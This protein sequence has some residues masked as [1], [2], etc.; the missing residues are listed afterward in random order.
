M[1]KC[2]IL[3]INIRIADAE[4]PAGDLIQQLEP[5]QIDFAEIEKV[6]AAVKA[7]GAER[8]P[9]KQ[10]SSCWEGRKT[11]LLFQMK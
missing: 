6:L 8:Q 1:A 10:P 7:I 11:L 3:E 9:G 4:L 5:T 2:I